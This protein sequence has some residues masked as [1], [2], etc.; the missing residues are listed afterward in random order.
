MKFDHLTQ[1]GFK[2]S[3]QI[4]LMVLTT[5]FPHFRRPTTEPELQLFDN[6]IAG[7]DR[8]FYR[9]PSPPRRSLERVFLAET[10]LMA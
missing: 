6:N 5:N 1:G 8:N 10:V 7:K 2:H 3:P 4:R 9:V